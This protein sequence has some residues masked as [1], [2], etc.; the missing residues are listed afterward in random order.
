MSYVLSCYE[1]LELEKI[2]GVCMGSKW[3]EQAK[4][5]E[6]RKRKAQSIIEFADIHEFCADPNAPVEEEAEWDFSS[7]DEAAAKA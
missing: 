3:I 2:I 6:A 4:Y 1:I 7:D 5:V